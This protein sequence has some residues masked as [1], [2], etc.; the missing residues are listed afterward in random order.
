MNRVER[1]RANA[2]RG[3]GREMAAVLPAGIGRMSANIEGAGT[4]IVSR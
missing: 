1:K 4:A 3:S 2:P